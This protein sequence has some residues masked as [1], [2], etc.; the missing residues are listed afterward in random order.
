[1]P[2]ELP[3][4]TLAPRGGRM[5]YSNLWPAAFAAGAVLS[6][7][8]PSQ[9]SPLAP[10]L[11]VISVTI[12][13][14]ADTIRVGS[15]VQ[16]TATIVASGNRTRIAT[17]SSPSAGIASVTSAGMVR[18]MAAGSTVVVAT[19]A[20][21]ADT[22]RVTV[23]DSATVADTTPPPPSGGAWPNEPL[24]FTTSSN[25]P[26]DTILS[27][28]WNYLRRASSEDDDIVS[29][30]SAPFSAPNVLRIHFTP[31]MGSNNEPSVHWIPLPGV[32]EIYTGWWIKLSANWQASPAGAGKMTFL[33]TNGVGQVYTNLYHQG[34]DPVNGWVNGPPYRVGVNTEWA[35]YG[36]NVLLPNATTTFI[37]PGEWHRV[38]AYYRWE[39]TP[40]VSG[41]GIIRWWVDGVL[42]G[43][44]T[45]VHY[46]A[47]SFIEY[48]YAPTLQNA[49]STTQYMYIDHTVVSKP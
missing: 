35:P 20:N 2:V 46:P 16:L 25:Q 38:E 12:T 14:A 48:Q 36:Q 49:P 11:S 27:N 22:A 42:N 30:P 23:I 21:K 4:L 17:W 26:W 45:N 19:S 1:M 13:P 3:N 40:G 5:R 37:N 28:G 18:G 10:D 47:S 8:A 15:T 32:Q 41:D 29:D 34:G 31:D 44:F 39:T 33:F 6:A 24:G 7:C 43:N 9:D